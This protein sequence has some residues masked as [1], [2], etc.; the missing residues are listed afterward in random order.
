MNYQYLRIKTSTL[1]CMGLLLWPLLV[2]AAEEANHEKT[3]LI[4]TRTGHKE[5]LSRAIMLAREARQRSYVPYSRFKMGAAVRTE[6]GNLVPGVL[7]EN[8][9]LGLSMCAERVA[10]FSAMAQNAGRPDLLVLVSPRTDG[11]LTFPCGACLQVALELGGPD[12]HVEACDLDGHCRGTRLH[13]LA[14]HLPHKGHK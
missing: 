3:P 8:V 1:L 6:N 13:E 5:Q 12:L 9:S 7:V 4:Q 10:L 11:H 14:P 2:S